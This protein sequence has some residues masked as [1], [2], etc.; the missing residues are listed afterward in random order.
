MPDVRELFEL[1]THDTEPK[2]DEWQRQE[3][4]QRRAMRRRKTGSFVVV[5]A[6]VVASLAAAAA[7]DHGGWTSAPATSPSGPLMSFSTHFLVNVATGERT[8]FP[9]SLPGARLVAVSPDGRTLAYNTCC[10]GA[11]YLALIDADGSNERTIA[12]GPI[13]GYASAW[14]PDGSTLVFQGRNPNGRRLGALYAY[15]VATDRTSKIVGFGQMRFGWWIVRPDVSPDGSTVVFHLPRGHNPTRWDLWTVPI[16]GGTPTLLRRNAGF[17]SYAPDGSIVFLDH[18]ENLAGAVWI[19]DADGTTA[20]E[21]V[22]GRSHAWPSASPDGMRVAY[23]DAGR[24][25]VVDV[26]GGVQR[27]VAF[28]AEPAWVDT[29]TLLVG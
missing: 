24:T 28:G 23:D 3:R 4:R 19:L 9:A 10:S 2:R 15:D 6:V 8:V 21:L 22:A 29:D 13:A 1:V 7:L 12:E 18:P 20:R 27:R 5:A 14:S 17:P 16:T 25:Y 11:D 26:S